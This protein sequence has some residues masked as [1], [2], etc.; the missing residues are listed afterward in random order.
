MIIKA[1]DIPEIGIEMLKIHRIA[2]CYLELLKIGKRIWDHFCN[3]I[4]QPNMGE[5]EGAWKGK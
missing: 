5:R 1:N 2:E 4:P 3:I